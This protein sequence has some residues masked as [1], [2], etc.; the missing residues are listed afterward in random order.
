VPEGRASPSRQLFL[1]YARWF[2]EA[3]GLASDPRYV[4]HLRRSNGT[5]EATLDDG[6]RIEARQVVSASGTFAHRHIPDFYRERLPRETYS[7]TTEAADLD[8]FAGRRVLVVGGGLSALEWSAILSE[9]G[10]D[11]QCAYRHAPWDVETGMSYIATHVME[12]RDLSEADPTWYRALPPEER[13]AILEKMRRHTPGAPWLKA[14]LGA[15]TFRP[16]TCVV[17]SAA[18]NGGVAVRFDTGETTEVDHII[19]GTG[20]V[21][22]VANVPYL[23]ADTIRSQLTVSNGYPAL[24]EQFE[25]SIDGLYFVGILALQDFGPIFRFVSGSGVA[26]PHILASL[27]TAS[28]AGRR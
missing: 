17:E 10:A 13:E 14:R 21:A 3:A 22:D 26:P 24:D 8:R 20:F 7:H 4:A 6:T 9:V 25:C 1:E 5:F 2:V 15:V 23:D 28:P 12:W 11:V 27:T 19:L 16:H 18:R